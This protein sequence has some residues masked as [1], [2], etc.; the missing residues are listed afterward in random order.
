MEISYYLTILVVCVAKEFS[1]FNFLNFNFDILLTLLQLWGKR[2]QKE[3]KIHLLVRI[4]MIANNCH[5]L[6]VFSL[7]YLSSF[8]FWKQK[9]N[10]SVGIPSQAEAL[11]KYYTVPSRNY[12]KL[13]LS[14]VIYK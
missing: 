13:L 7:A 2:G 10:L 11:G 6:F 4:L 14:I 8:Y 3:I 1:H 12:L 5:F 9:I